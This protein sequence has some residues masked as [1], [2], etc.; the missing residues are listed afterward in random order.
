MWQTNTREKGTGKFEQE[1]NGRSY[2]HHLI[3]LSHMTTHSIFSDLLT[4]K[5]PTQVLQLQNSLIVKLN[6]IRAD[7]VTSR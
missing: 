7:G 1:K 6:E 5:I 2:F 3:I 4:D